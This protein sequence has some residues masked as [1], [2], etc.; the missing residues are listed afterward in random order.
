MTADLNLTGNPMVVD[1]REDKIHPEEQWGREHFIPIR[2]IDLVAGLVKQG[3]LDSDSQERFSEFVRLFEAILHYEYHHRLE[4]LKDLYSGFNPD[5]DT[6]TPEKTCEA[7]T[8]QKCC[9][10]FFQELDELLQSANYKQL[11]Q[12]E[13]DQAVGAASHWGVRLKVNFEIF[14]HLVVYARGDVMGSRVLRRLWN[15]NRP[16]EVEV[17]IYQKLV[18]V[19]RLRD[20]SVL[21]ERDDSETI[22]IKLFKN[23]PKQDVDMLLPGTSV[24]MTWIDQG[25]I[26]LPT[27]SGVVISIVKLTKAFAMLAVAGVYG[28]LVFLGLV[29]GTIGYGVK[30]FF[31][32]LR[33]KDKYQLN[34]TRS[35]YYQNL[36][37]NA[38][39]LF[40]LL[41]EAEEQE[42]RE[43]VLGYWLLWRE[44]PDEGWTRQ[45]LD[46]RAESFLRDHFDVDV[47]FEIEDVEAKLTRYGLIQRNGDCL[48]AV[49][50]RE[51]LAGLDRTWDNYFHHG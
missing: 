35:L 17:R 8:R 33:T 5:A 32:Y 19:F 16:E 37:N 28:M 9:V 14:E 42:F 36:D 13:I 41:D 48:R 12:E 1:P 39:V 24:R 6:R 26:F 30:S 50:I 27:I 21:D 4:S 51:A 20:Q 2:K 34:L 44:A 46:R 10:L 47:D 18:V 25:K 11:S 40:R 3:Q 45:D 7:A 49:P 15:W 29:G 43:A 22:Y 23:I 38:G 31:G